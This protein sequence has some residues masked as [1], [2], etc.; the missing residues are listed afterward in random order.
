MHPEAFAFVRDAVAQLGDLRGKAV[1]EIGSFNINGTVRELFPRTDYTGIDVREGPGVDEVADGATYQGG[2]F[3]IVVST[4]V[5]EHTP[6]ADAIVLHA[7]E[8]LAP[9]GYL[10]LTVAGPGREPHGVDGGAVGDEFYQTIDPDALKTWLETAGLV[11]IDVRRNQQAHDVYA[12]ARKPEADAKTETGEVD[13]VFEP[14]P[15]FE[16]EI[17]R[18][19]RPTRGKK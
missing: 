5:L 17:A 11:D 8:L 12:A 14:L 3:D 10:V 18:V 6:M 16:A 7:A 2:P 4:E 13:V 19:S 9:G 15:P 1:L